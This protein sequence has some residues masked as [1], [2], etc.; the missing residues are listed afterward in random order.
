MGVELDRLTITTTRSERRGQVLGGQ[1]R[2]R[3]RFRHKPDRTGFE[4]P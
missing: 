4:G 2:R 3:N 1:S